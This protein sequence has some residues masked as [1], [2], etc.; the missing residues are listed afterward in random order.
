MG[1]LVASVF[2]LGGLYL[3]FDPPGHADGVVKNGDASDRFFASAKIVHLQIQ[4][5][6]TNLNALRR[7]PRA[8]VSATIREGDRV[9]NGVG[10]HLKGAAGSFRPVDDETPAFTLNFDKFEAGQKF[11]GLDKLHLN[12]SVQDRSLLTEAICSRLFLEAEVPTPRATHARVELNGRDLGLYVLKEGFDRTFLRRHFKNPDGNLYDGGFLR[13]ITDP[14]R[15]SSGTNDVNDWSD[16]KAL[17]AAAREP[18]PGRR[19]E[20]LEKVL[21]LDRFL[22]FVALEMMTW[23]WDG[24]T[25]KRNNYRVFHDLDSGKMVFL[26]HGMDQMFWFPNEEILPKRP[27]GLVAQAVLSTSEGRRRYMAR[28]S[29][30]LTNVFVVEKLTNHIQE[31]RSRVRPELESISPEQ[32]RQHD[33]E[34]RKLRTHVVQRVAVVRQRLSEPEAQPVQF[35]TAGTL[36]LEAWRMLDLRGTA[37]LDIQTDTNGVKTL[38]VVTGPEGRCTGSW[39]HRVLLPPGRYVFEGRVRTTAVVPLKQDTGKKGVGAGL[40]HARAPK[41]RANGVV[42]DTPWQKLEYEFVLEDEE[43]VDLLCELRAEKGEAWFDLASLK[44]RKH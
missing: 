19:L 24:Y 22:T 15:K 13:E 43:E 16:L 34:V 23:H 18:N 27:E 37:R 25:M 6:G 26:P 33:A 28:A 44:L 2:A 38:H 41:A 29:S 42:G 3:C 10:V 7:D 11:H 17:V 35:G 9:Y 30:L 32:A 21:D 31:L 36:A 20:R 4:I 1:R 14:L 12:N 40:R 39:R 5:A 8:Y